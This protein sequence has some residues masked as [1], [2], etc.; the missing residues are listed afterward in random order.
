MRNFLTLICS[1]LIF[2]VGFHRVFIE[3]V[4]AVSLVVAY[5]FMITG[6]IGVITNASNLIRVFAERK[7]RDNIL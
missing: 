2:F 4:S 3:S 7:R 5:I 1:M 6:L